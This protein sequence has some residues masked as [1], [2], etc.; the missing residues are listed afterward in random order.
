M[1]YKTKAEQMFTE[2]VDI[3]LAHR[4]FA[5][6]EVVFHQYGCYLQLIEAAPYISESK[7][8]VFVG[9]NEPT[10]EEEQYAVLSG[11]VER[12]CHE[13]LRVESQMMLI[14]RYGFPLVP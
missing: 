4:D 2:K 14:G 10:V 12:V 5:S 9:H 7:E 11:E 1:S 8:L 13:M 6:L 3:A